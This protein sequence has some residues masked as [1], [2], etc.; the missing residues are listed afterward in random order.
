MGNQDDFS[1]ADTINLH[2]S[3]QSIYHNDNTDD[4]NRNGNLYNSSSGHDKHTK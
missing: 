1:S 3:L 4:N 2:G